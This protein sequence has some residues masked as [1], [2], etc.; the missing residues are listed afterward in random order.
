MR[1]KEIWDIYKSRFKEIE[2]Y[3]QR[4]VHNFK[5]DD[6]HSFRVQIKKLD[7]FIR[8]V[9][10]SGTLQKHKIPKSIRKF[11]RL[12]GNIR[13]L[14]LNQERISRL[15]SDLSIKNP[16][17]YLQYLH[18]DEDS[19]RIKALRLAKRSSFKKLE[20]QL[21]EDVPT[22]LPGQA[23]DAFI[24]KT[25][26]RLVQLFTLPVLFDDTLHDVRKIVKDL[27][28]NYQYVEPSGSNIIPPVLTGLKSMKKLTE[29]LGDFHDLCVAIFFIDR[30]MGNHFVEQNE[31]TILAELKDHF[32]VR[33]QNMMD[34]IVQSFAPIK[35]GQV[36]T[37]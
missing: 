28:Y 19:K 30:A 7:A 27:V 36:T 12:L 10:L 6:I 33:K 22:E 17:S 14:Q 29:V 37:S 32:L 3:Y 11:Y 5:E 18:N 13:N 1:N 34:E 20:K 26:S 15:V 4:L 31:K 2:K 24:E 8:L 23:K 16:S 21:V 9:N 35:Q 25:K